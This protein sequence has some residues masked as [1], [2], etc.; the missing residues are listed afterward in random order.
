MIQKYMNNIGYLH[1]RVT[2]DNEPDWDDD[3]TAFYCNRETVSVSAWNPQANVSSGTL[4]EIIKTTAQLNF[5]INDKI[6]F[7][8]Q[9]LNDVNSGDA[10]LIT[11]IEPK[12][13][14]EQGN[15]HRTEQYYEYRI[16]IA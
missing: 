3:S 7:F 4:E 12:P 16:T 14:M 5:E 13:I 2:T 10:S 9:P 11:A 15:K 1:K 6:A 8:P